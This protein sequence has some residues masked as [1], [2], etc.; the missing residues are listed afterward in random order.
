MT[1]WQGTAAHRRIRPISEHV[2]TLPVVRELPPRPPDPV[3]AQSL[4]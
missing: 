3:G 4:W 1:I 2:Y